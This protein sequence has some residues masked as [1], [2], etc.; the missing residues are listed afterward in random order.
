MMNFDNENVLSE[1]STSSTLNGLQAKRNFRDSGQSKE[2]KRNNGQQSS[3][4]INNKAGGDQ[5]LEI[6]AMKSQ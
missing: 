5:Y 6:R 3:L 1:E 4:G 2:I